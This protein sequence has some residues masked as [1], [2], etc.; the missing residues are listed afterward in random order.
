[1]NLDGANVESVATPAVKVQQWPLQM[2]TQLDKDRTSTFRSATMRASYMSVNRVDVQ[3]AMLKR[4]TRYFADHGRLV[5]VISEQR[6]VKAPRVDTDSVCAGMIWPSQDKEFV[7]HKI[8]KLGFTLKFI[9]KR[10][11]RSWGRSQW[12]ET[13]RKT[14]IALL[15][16]VQRTDA[17]WVEKMAAEWD[18]VPMLLQVL[19]LCFDGSFHYNWRC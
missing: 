16:C 3:Q 14:S 4:P 18:T 5:Q 6:Y 11:L 12:N 1:M 15:Q 10:P 19:Q 9:K 17:H 8:S 13:R 7:G 2:V